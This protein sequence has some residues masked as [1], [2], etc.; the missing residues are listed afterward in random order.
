MW[1]LGLDP[2]RSGA[3]V[4]LAPDRYAEVL[5]SWRTQEDG[6]IL[7]R[8]AQLTAEGIAVRKVRLRSPHALGEMLVAGLIAVAGADP[9]LVG[10]E[11]VHVGKNAATGI[12]QALWLGQVLG[13]VIHA[14]GVQPRWARPTEWR[15][16]VGVNPRLRG[17][18]VKRD[19]VRV[20]GATCPGLNELVTALQRRSVLAHDFEAGGV[21][22]WLAG[23]EN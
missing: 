11:A 13:P 19:A 6:S 9:V 7:L 4:A 5:W 8:I 21:A 3:A 23:S 20:L 2:G 16:A 18:D 17:K 15:K 10:S 1:Y 12:Q 14:L 22:K